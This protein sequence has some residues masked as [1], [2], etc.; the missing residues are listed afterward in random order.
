MFD[1][2]VKIAK[3]KE[4]D[5]ELLVQ[6]ADEIR[7]KKKG[8]TAYSIKK[9]NDL[10]FVLEKD[11]YLLN[12]LKH[13]LGLLFR[14]RK[15]GVLIA[16][17]GII[18]E[19]GFFSEIKKRLY[20]KI[21]PYQPAPNTM[22]FLVSNVFYNA[23]DH[24]WVS[25]IE[26]AQWERLFELLDI[27]PIHEQSNNAFAVTEILF[28]IELLA[29][30]VCGT[31]MEQSLLK[32]VPEYEN[33]DSPF[34]ALQKEMGSFSDVLKSQREARSG[35][36]LDIKQIK[37]LIKQCFAYLDRAFINKEKYGI[38][39]L[40]TVKLQK[41]QQQ[42]DR[43]DMLLNFLIVD[44]KLRRHEKMIAFIKG[45]IRLNSNKNK[46]KQ[47]WRNT[48]RLIS[49]QITQHTGKTG[50]HY[51]TE[52][53]SEYN[54][55]FISAAG[56]GVVVGILCLFKALYSYIDTSPF[57]HAFYYS[58]NY[59]L[60]FIAIYLMHFTLATKQPAMTAATLAR[61]IKPGKEKRIDYSGFANL[62]SRLFRT[63]FIAF[64]GNVVFALPTAILVV[65]LWE[66][67]ISSEPFIKPYKAEK[68]LGEINPFKTPALLHA[69]VAGF[70]LFL[71]GLISGYFINRNIH[72]GISYRIQ[73]HPVL[74]K[75]FPSSFLNKLGALY[76]RHIGG[77]SG[78]FWLGVFLGSTG[79]LGY[80]FGIN[81]DIRHITFSAGN[82]G[83]AMQ[84][85]GLSI[86][87]WDVVIGII[88]IGLIGFINFIVSF[89]LSLW[90]ALRSRDLR[91]I[92]L[93]PIAAAIWERFKLGKRDFFIPPPKPVLPITEKAGESHN[94]ASQS[95]T[96][97]E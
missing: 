94:T 5:P 37:I 49:Y 57:G 35:D 95:H 74:I 54:K 53:Q 93:I 11:E 52:T 64:V 42:L 55:M 29:M 83:L 68:L 18:A 96:K 31:A 34:I 19:G 86:G 16:D 1:T 76:T 4:T 65:Y 36:D 88:C 50:E 6:L 62:F 97:T 77:L 32:M 28:S 66:Y 75:L 84:G 85:L 41:M 9:F 61:A 33:L 7:P 79:I 89:S 2:L 60:G 72:E 70:Y 40:T 21:L 44:Q 51:I 73:R 81:I 46:I 14:N 69:G 90:V 22:D 38:S 8:D 58:M 15:F 12:G 92:E 45:I 30:R 56:G 10:I 43:M 67:F 13:Y 48:T 71:S 27:K 82:L 59:A 63:Q 91:F 25:S 39:F 78:N 3:S 80:F 17:L 26:D 24:K 20:N 87:I 47:F 23:M